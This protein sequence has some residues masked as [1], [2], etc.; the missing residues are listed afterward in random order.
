MQVTAQQTP[1]PPT[2]SPFNVNTSLHDDYAV[3]VFFRLPD[4]LH[5]AD[6]GLGIESDENPVVDEPLAPC[7]EVGVAIPIYVKTTDK[8]EKIYMEA[9]ITKAI[10]RGSL[11]GKAFYHKGRRLYPEDV[12]GDVGIAFYDTVRLKVRLVLIVLP[13]ILVPLRK[14]D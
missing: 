14:P 4:D 7:N 10:N 1:L 2:S 12:I 6:L 13:K 5:E 8:V 9:A 3:F 11:R